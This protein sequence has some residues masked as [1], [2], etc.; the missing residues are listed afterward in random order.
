[1]VSRG[2]P[3]VVR[4]GPMAKPLLASQAS[5]MQPTTSSAPARMTRL[6]TSSEDAGLF[7]AFHAAVGVEDGVAGGLGEVRPGGGG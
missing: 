1:M 2:M 4:V 5:R 6:R 7:C 3:L